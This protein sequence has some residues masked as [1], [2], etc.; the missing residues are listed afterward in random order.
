MN[1]LSQYLPPYTYYCSVLRIYGTLRCNRIFAKFRY[2][3]LYR[4]SAIKHKT[5]SW[6]KS[7]YRVIYILYTVYLLLAHIVYAISVFRRYKWNLRSSGMLR[8]VWWYFRTDVSGQTI[9]P[10]FKKPDFF[11]LKF[12]TLED[13]FQ[14]LF[15]KVGTELPF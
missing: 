5:T 13:G 7:R 11:L 10:I 12:L 15:R 2:G 8:S 6:A 9:S 4:P 1:C 14:R 3:T